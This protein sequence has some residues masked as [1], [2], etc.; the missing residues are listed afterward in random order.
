MFFR[1]SFC[2]LFFSLLF[3][4]SIKLLRMKVLRQIKTFCEN[5]HVVLSKHP[6][7]P[8]LVG[9]VPKNTVRL[10]QGNKVLLHSGIAQR[11]STTLNK[12][13]LKVSIQV[14]NRN[15]DL[16]IPITQ[17][18]CFLTNLMSIFGLEYSKP[19][20]NIFINKWLLG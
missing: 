1:L 13:D 18:D 2:L 11:S 3:K 16:I 12:A 10:K 15:N 5:L 20:D 17:H 8:A 9:C 14:F 6:C 7:R 4:L 19:W